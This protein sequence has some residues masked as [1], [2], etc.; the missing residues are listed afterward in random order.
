MKYRLAAF[1][2]VLAALGACQTETKTETSEQPIMKVEDPHS[3][4][5]PEESVVTH[6]DWHAMVDFDS[7]IITAKASLSIENAENAKE[8]V[9]DAKDLNVSKITLGKDDE[10]PAEYQLG[11]SDKIMGAPLTIKITPDVRTVNIYYTTSPKAEALQW[12]SPTQT[13]GKKYPF[14][15]TQSEAILARTWVPIQDSPGIRF[16]Y[17][18]DV[19]V[20]SELLALMS[21][22]NP[23]KKDEEGKYHFKMEQPIPAYLLALAVGDLEFESISD[24]TGVYAEPSVV[25]T[26]KYEFGE[27]EEMVSAAEE[28]YG[29]YQWGRYDIIV[30]P[31]S[32]PFGGMENP[33]LTFATPTIL[34]GDRSLTSLVAHE[35][36]HSWSGNLVTNATW[37]DFWLNEGFT[38]Y[39]EHRIMEKL[40]GKDYSEM[41]ASLAAQDLKAEV[42]DMQENNMAG[43]TRLRLELEGR[44]P[45]DGVTSIAYDKGYLFLR[46]LEEAAGREKFDAFVK[47]YFSRNAFKSMTTEEFIKQLDEYLLTEG[48]I[49]IGMVKIN[50]WI[51]QPGL[52]DDIPTPTSDRFGKVD[53]ELKKFIMGTPPAELDTANWSSHEWLHFVRSIPDSIAKEHF[54]ELDEAFAFTKTGNSEVVAAW[55]EQSIN[56][57]YAPADQRLEDFLVHT[58]RRKFLVPLYKALIQTEDGKKRALEIYEKAR[59]NYHFVSTNTLDEML[60]W[61][62][63]N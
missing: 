28:L 11:Q 36:A 52:P 33:R 38:V 16:T 48:R 9:L 61:E 15:F 18:A 8:L 35:L 34:A 37:N 12:L 29:D 60:N 51:H 42:A 32:F 62:E 22:R 59:P 4:A 24:R 39:F 41:L 47:D 50:E 21:A 27:L 7:T 19:E 30:L 57:N 58:G 20:P 17:T 63:Y 5:K 55:L 43:D 3:Y 2:V 6:L 10:Q 49:N 26:A 40:Y 23:Q 46:Y 25:E 1:I 14:L 45:D 13:S 31:P 54:A 53:E 44:N 56:N